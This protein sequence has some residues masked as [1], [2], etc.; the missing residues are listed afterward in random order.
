MFNKIVIVG[1]VG[2]VQQLKTTKSGSQMCSFSVAVTTGWGDGKQTDWYNVTVFGKQA[3]SCSKLSKGSLVCVS[4]TLQL[5]EYDGKDGQKK[6]R[7]DITSDSVTFMNHRSNNNGTYQNTQSV[8]QNNPQEEE[9]EN[10]FI[11]S[12]DASLPF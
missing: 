7:L 5:H 8:P 4:G 6:A 12:V 9:P 11:D 1:N 3:E 10:P 2:F